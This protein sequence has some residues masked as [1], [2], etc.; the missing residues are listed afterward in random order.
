MTKLTA[1]EAWNKSH[2][3]LRHHV[4]FKNDILTDERRA[5]ILAQEKKKLDD[6]RR[7]LDQ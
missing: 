5:E 7:R 4:R 3:A 1:Q 2:S 6:I